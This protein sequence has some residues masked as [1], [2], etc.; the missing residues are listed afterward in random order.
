MIVMMEREIKVI[1]ISNLDYFFITFYKNEK[2]K[3]STI[4]KKFL[5]VIK[6]CQKFYI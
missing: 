4:L 1:T 2:K 6:P 3:S 5:K